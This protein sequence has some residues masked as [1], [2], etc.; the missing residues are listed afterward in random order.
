MTSLNQNLPN[1]CM[2]SFRDLLLE[3]GQGSGTDVLMGLSQDDRNAVVKILCDDIYWGYDDRLGTDGLVYTAFYEKNNKPKVLI[4][5]DTPIICS[6]IVFS[7]KH[8]GVTCDI[9]N[10]GLEA[11][12]K[13]KIIHY[14]LIFMDGEMP[15]MSGIDATRILRQMGI[16]TPIIANTG[17]EELEN[18]FLEAGITAFYTKQKLKPKC[19]VKYYIYGKQK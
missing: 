9:V 19:C 18:D 11:I 14:D 17:N 7:L 4:V 13:C 12:E 8:L 16:T 6:M 3:S 2:Y 10:D 15:N 1:S 5:D